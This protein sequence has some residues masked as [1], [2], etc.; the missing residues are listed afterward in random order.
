ML[1]A[2]AP[3]RSLGADA[4]R[5]QT[6][7]A[8]APRERRVVAGLEST[9]A[10]G[11]IVWI[12][13]VNGGVVL[14][15]AGFDESGAQIK[16]ALHGR[17][18]LAILLTHGHLDHRSA[19]HLFGAPVYLGRGDLDLALG[20]A[21]ARAPLARLADLV[22]APPAP[23]ALIPVDDGEVLYLG[24]RRF[25]AIALPGHTAGSTGWQLGRLLF[26]GDA[27][28]GPLGDGELWPAPPTVTDDM[29]AAY[30]SMRK[31]VTLDIDTV[32]DGHFGRT[33]DVNAA[34][35]RAV[36]RV[37]DDDALLE[38]PALRPAGCAEP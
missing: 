9:C 28:Q 17:R 30:A 3:V 2:C 12:V 23:A 31:L 6:S 37:H 27:V 18:V 38:H 5:L 13:P 22:G 21:G 32:L 11:S 14:V 7:V 8:P 16:A 34:A 25:T 4:M 10:A 24:M 20:K 1:V 26:T 15:D 33:D 36:R 19:A 29:R 35:T